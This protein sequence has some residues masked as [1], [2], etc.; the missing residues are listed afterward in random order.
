MKSDH[1]RLLGLL[2]LCLEGSQFLLKRGDLALLNSESLVGTALSY[3]FEGLDLNVFL[4][5][6]LQKE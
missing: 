1:A 4:L 5:Q 6:L 2:L 3:R